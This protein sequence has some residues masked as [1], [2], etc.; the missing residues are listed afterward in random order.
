M[1]QETENNIKKINQELSEKN[2][3][4]DTDSIK[5][6]NWITFYLVNGDGETFKRSH[7]TQ[8]RIDEIKNI[9][10]KATGRGCFGKKEQYGKLRFGYSK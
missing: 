5:E 4:I 9:I 7:T 2:L 3:L 10:K 6:G 1:R 8:G